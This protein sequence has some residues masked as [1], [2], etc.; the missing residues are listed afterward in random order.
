MYILQKFTFRRGSHHQLFPRYF[1]L[2]GN[3]TKKEDSKPVL[4]D[5]QKDEMEKEL[6]N[7]KTISS[8]VFSFFF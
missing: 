1:C 5:Q 7:I 2:E 3:E 8:R 6:E 4:T